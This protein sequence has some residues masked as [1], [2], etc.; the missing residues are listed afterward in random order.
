MSDAPPFMR[1]F[2]LHPQPV[3]PVREANLDLYLPAGTEPAA[4]IVFVHGG[5][6]PRERRA[7]PRDWPVYRGYGSAAAARGFVG[8]TFDHRFL[9]LD[10][11]EVAAEDIAAAITRVRTNLRGDVSIALW[12]FSG[13]AMLMGKWLAEPPTWLRCVAVSY[14]VFATKEELGD[15]AISPSEALWSS[16]DLPILLTRVGLERPEFAEKVEAFVATAA[17]A[18]ANLEIIDVPDGR[19]GFDVLDDT[20]QSRAAVES[21]FEWVGSRVHTGA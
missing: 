21:A 19:H 13:G 18:G 6:I 16:G 1:P 5:P 7:T 12:F 14:P 8:A 20:R 3:I 15:V 11:I 10:S 4:A 17:D 9:D 2:V